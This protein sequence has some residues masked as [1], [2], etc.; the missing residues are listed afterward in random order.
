LGVPAERR[1]HP[2]GDYE[3][4]SQKRSCFLELF[5]FQSGYQLVRNRLYYG[6][7]L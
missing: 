3:T 2:S 7:S 5:I 4:I 6:E 1:S